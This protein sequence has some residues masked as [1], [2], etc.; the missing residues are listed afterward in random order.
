MESSCFVANAA[1][2]CFLSIEEKKRVAFSLSLADDR[3]A[4]GGGLQYC[5]LVR[6]CTSTGRLRTVLRTFVLT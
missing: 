4:V 2:G 3:Q 6:Y 5:V 1:G